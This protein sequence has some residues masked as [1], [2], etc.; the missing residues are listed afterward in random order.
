MNNRRTTP[1]GQT[2]HMLS[3]ILAKV[4]KMSDRTFLRRRNDEM[5]SFHRDKGKIYYRRS[6]VLRAMSACIRSSSISTAFSPDKQAYS[7]CCTLVVSI[8]LVSC[9]GRHTSKVLSCPSRLSTLIVPPSR[10]TSR[11]VIES[12]S[13]FFSASFI[14]LPSVL[15]ILF[16]AC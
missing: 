10:L 12:P 1:G 2:P 6:G 11:A 16:A 4:T 13:P 15:L 14:P 3:A 7:T 8:P 9:M 5:L